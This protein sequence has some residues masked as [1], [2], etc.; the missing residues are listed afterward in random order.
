MRLLTKLTSTKVIVLRIKFTTRAC[1]AFSWV[2]YW[3]FL[4][5]TFSFYPLISQLYFLQ[6]FT[7]SNALIDWVNKKK[8]HF[9]YLPLFFGDNFFIRF[10]F[11]LFTYRFKLFVHFVQF[12]IACLFISLYTAYPSIFIPCSCFIHLPRIFQLY[13]LYIQFSSA[14]FTYLVCKFLNTFIKFRWWNVYFTILVYLY[15]WVS[16]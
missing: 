3:Y 2:V 8:F 1:L 16:F 15:L 7:F 11:Q 10:F 9:L 12:I 5:I 4:S 13:F 14:I 6:I